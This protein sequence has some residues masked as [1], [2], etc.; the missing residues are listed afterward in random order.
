MQTSASTSQINKALFKVQGSIGAIKRNAENEHFSK[1]KKK[2]TY[3]TWD[4]MAEVVIEAFQ[5]H[6]ILMEMEEGEV[7]GYKS[8]SLRLT[9]VESEE[10]KVYAPYRIKES[11][12]G[13]LDHNAGKSTKYAMKQ[14]LVLALGLR[15]TDED[16]D[17]NE[18]DPPNNK[19][20]V[21]IPKRSSEKYESL[22]PQTDL[23]LRQSEEISS[24]RVKSEEINSEEA[25]RKN[26]HQRFMI[27]CRKNGIEDDVRLKT[28]YNLTR[29]NSSTLLTIAEM[30]LVHGELAKEYAS[31]A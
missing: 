3:A 29:K 30:T 16:T 18:I 13:N 2:A 25:K 10:F 23:P 21:L 1:G 11:S 28:I 17:G 5:K 22:C 20:N 7:E 4:D 19:K 26:A 14:V 12:A 8:I 9:H 6:G 31:S 24:N 27:W 15:G